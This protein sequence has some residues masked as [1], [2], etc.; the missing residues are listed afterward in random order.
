MGAV[1][2]PVRDW[3]T[4]EERMLGVG[5]RSG[6]ERHFPGRQFGN[7]IIARPAVRRTDDCLSPCRVVG[8]LSYSYNKVV[9]IFTAAPVERWHGGPESADG[10][11][12]RW[13]GAGVD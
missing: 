13:D 7:R 10:A 3:P 9:S 8:M 11:V 4:R 1:M 12:P 2:I 6:R 5:T